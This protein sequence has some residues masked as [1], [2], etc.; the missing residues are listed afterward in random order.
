MM[1]LDLWVCIFVFA[2]HDFFFFSNTAIICNP[3]HYCKIYFLHPVSLS[4]STISGIQKCL[5]YLY[6]RQN[7]VIE[8]INFINS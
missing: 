1:F 4:F 8:I 2:A 3:I 6:L 7:G 5:L